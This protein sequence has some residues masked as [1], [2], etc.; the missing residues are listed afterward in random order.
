MKFHSIQTNQ[1]LDA[2]VNNIIVLEILF[3]NS[4]PLND[5]VLSEFKLI[6]IT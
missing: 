5:S 2:I 4:F 6:K 3:G 1:I